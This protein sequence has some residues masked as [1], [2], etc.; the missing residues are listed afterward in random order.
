MMSNSVWWSG[1][2]CRRVKRQHW[3]KTRDDV[4]ATLDPECTQLKYQRNTLTSHAREHTRADTH[5]RVRAYS[6]S[7]KIGHTYSFKG[8]SL[9]LLFSTL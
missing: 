8:F 7:Q 5:K 9:C 2:K 3:A 4:A 6:T 1:Q